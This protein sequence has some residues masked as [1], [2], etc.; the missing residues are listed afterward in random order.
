[1]L[2]ARR[3]D[4]AVIAALLGLAFAGPAAAATEISCGQVISN[5]GVYSL[6]EDLNCTD[7]IEIRAGGVTFD[8]QGH[9][10]SGYGSER[11][12]ILIW[13]W[14]GSPADPVRVRNGIIRGFSVPPTDA[15]GL[16]GV[17]VGAGYVRLQRLSLSQNEIGVDVYGAGASAEIQHN[18]IEHN[19]GWGVV[20]RPGAAAYVADNRIVRNGSGIYATYTRGGYV[21]NNFVA[22][23]T[24]GGVGVNNAVPV[25]GNM[26]IH[27]GGNGLTLTSG[28]G[29]LGA[30]FQVAID[31][32]AIGNGGYGIWSEFPL[33]PSNATGNRAAGNGSTPQCWNVVCSP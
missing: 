16:A 6:G 12:G 28:E 25:E 29:T 26:L 31:N 30:Q 9:T 14:N 10:L 32:L 1:M 7:A 24:Y 11:M 27:N 13:V 2:R 3:A 33:V 8:L 20:A 22:F 21:R 5:P 23:T 15:Y 18:V 19:G 17:W 4:V